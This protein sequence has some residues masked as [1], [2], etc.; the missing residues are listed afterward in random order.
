MKYKILLTGNNKAIIDDLFAKASDRFEYQTS[1]AR[2]E[3]ILSHLRHFK[4]NGFLYC[5]NHEM[6]ESF[7][8]MADLKQSPEAS[9]TAFFAVGTRAECDSY[10]RTVP[11]VVDMVL[12]KPISTSIMEEKMNGYFVSL[13]SNKVVV[14]A[15]PPL[16]ASLSAANTVPA[17]NGQTGTIPLPGVGLA[18]Q[19]QVNAKQPAV[20]PAPASLQPKT[21]NQTQAVTPA[22]AVMQQPGAGIQQPAAPASAMPNLSEDPNDELLLALTEQ[23]DSAAKMIDAIANLPSMEAENEDDAGRRKHILVVD[24]DSRMLKII[25]RHLSDKYDVA[26][27]LNGRLALKF[28]ETKKTDLILLDYE[29][30]LENGPAILKKLRDNPYTHDIPVIFLTGISEREK[31]EKALVMKPQGYLLKPIDHIKLLSS[32]SKLIG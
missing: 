12:E 20:N 31:I 8:K 11:D 22:A 13:R 16:T 29:M 4:P 10:T 1:S 27:A 30:P 17:S 24:D 18:A 23:V 14:P 5:I 9:A 32:I 7:R 2:Y 6:P 21:V 15:A 28:L 25:K 19:P 3:D 26:T